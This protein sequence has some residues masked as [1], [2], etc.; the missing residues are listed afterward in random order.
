MAN[1]VASSLW[2]A[3]CTI[4]V[5]FVVCRAWGYVNGTYKKKVEKKGGGGNRHDLAPLGP[6]SGIVTIVP[7][8]KYPHYYFSRLAQHTAHACTAARQKRE[9]GG[10]D[11]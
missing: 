6:K 4:H 8:T 10:D 5:L 3:P 2:L 1:V 11:R 9:R 7:D